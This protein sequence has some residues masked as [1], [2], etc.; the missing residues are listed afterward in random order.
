[1][2]ARRRPRW[3]LVAATVAAGVV[4]TGAALQSRPSLLPVVTLHTPAAVT[5]PSIGWAPEF[6]DQYGHPARWDPCLPIH[7]VVNTVS[8]PA[9]ALADL[10]RALA[11]VSRA[12][13]LTFVDDGTTSE[14]P[15]PDR[16]AYQPARY[17]KRWAP[18]LVAWVSRS[19]TSLIDEADAE[20]VTVPIAVPTS[21]GGV[22]VSAEVA[23]N[24]DQQLPVG[25]RTDGASEGEVLLHE[26]GHAVGL[27]HVA[28]RADAMFPTVRGIAA[29]GEGDLAGLAAVGRGAGCLAEPRPR[30]ISVQ[31]HSGS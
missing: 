1:M 20:G 18:M 8:A 7:Y 12:T 13:G 21:Q 19:R 27:A 9:G 30:H 28:N 15:T 25:F 24:T 2:R 4:A 16:S 3:L 17:G 23:L 22:L 14:I 5:D 29:Y 26:L 10:R 6:V 11:T 31:P